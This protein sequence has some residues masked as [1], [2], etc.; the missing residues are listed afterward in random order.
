MKARIPA[1]TFA[2]SWS[3]APDSRLKAM[4]ARRAVIHNNSDSMS[5]FRWRDHRIPRDATH[6]SAP[7]TVTRTRRHVV[8]RDDLSSTFTLTAPEPLVQLGPPLLQRRFHPGHCAPPFLYRHPD[9]RLKNF[10]MSELSEHFSA[11][12]IGMYRLPHGLQQHHRRNGISRYEE[13]ASLNGDR[14]SRTRDTRC[15]GTERTGR[16]AVGR[17]RAAAAIWRTLAWARLQKP[18]RGVADPASCRS[19]VDRGRAGSCQVE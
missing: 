1:V 13:P 19:S 15:L 16:Q 10:L 3:R 9:G 12:A 11:I 17:S 18:G 14:Y 8:T 7:A 2:S 6:D 4:G 5:I